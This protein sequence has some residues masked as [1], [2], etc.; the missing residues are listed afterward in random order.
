MND[1]SF[2]FAARKT[3]IQNLIKIYLL[4]LEIKTNHLPR[5]LFFIDLNLLPTYDFPEP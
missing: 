4:V 1:I 2:F 5:S 3:K